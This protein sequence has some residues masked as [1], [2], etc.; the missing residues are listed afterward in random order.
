MRKLFFLSLFSLL[1]IATSVSLHAQSKFEGY[2]AGTLKTADGDNIA[3]ILKI[4]NGVA[5]EY[6]YDKD[7]KK[8]VAYEPDKE[9]TNWQ[10]NNL[11]FTWMNQGG[12]WTETQTYMLSYLSGKKLSAI[13]I[14]QVNN[15]K[16]DEDENSCWSVKAE[17]T[18]T[19]YTKTALEAL[20]D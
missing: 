5:K 11:C 10:R 20:F 6:N 9:V 1:L 15:I 17:G 7:Q 3:I 2:W 19:Y 12:V 13:W 8:L 18:L 4:T 14:R 16:D